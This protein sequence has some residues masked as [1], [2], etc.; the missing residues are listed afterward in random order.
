MAASARV[1]RSGSAMPR[2]SRPISTLA[3]TVSQGRRAK[4]WKTMATPWLAPLSS[5]P[6]YDTVPAVG[7]MSPAMQRSS[8]DLPD[9]DL[10]SR[11]TISPSCNRR[12]TSSRTGSSWP[13]GVAK[14]LVT[15]ATSM[16]T[17]VSGSGV[18]SVAGVVSISLMV[19]SRSRGHA[20]E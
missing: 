11:A 16:M 15:W 6:R 18:G 20:N 8:V 13:S 12:L 14:C 9:P 4:L 17:G 5:S 1:R 7:A 3:R 10:P 19:V 2:A